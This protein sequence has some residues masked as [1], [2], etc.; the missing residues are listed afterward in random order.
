MS[1]E[2][3]LN[4]RRVSDSVTTSGS[5][6]AEDLGQLR[7]HGYDVVVNLLPDRS[8]YAV[9]GEETIVGDQ[10]LEYVYIPIDFATPTHKQF[11]EF[12]AAMDAH[13]GKTIHVHC[14]ANYRVSAFYS[15]YAMAKGWWSE[16]QADEH[17]R[18]IWTQGE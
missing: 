4:F 11:E 14:A 5:V 6:P 17:L 12:V 3:S 10:D 16:G 15:L 18:G 9:E 13:A 1:I 2:S 7:S 8:G